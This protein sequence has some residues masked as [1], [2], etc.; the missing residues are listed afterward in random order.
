MVIASGV[1][2]HQYGETAAIVF[3]FSSSSLRAQVE[4]VGRFRRVMLHMT[5]FRLRKC[6]LWVT[7][8]TNFIKGSISPLKSQNFL[9]VWVRVGNV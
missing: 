6:L 1:S 9:L 5:R 2:F 7:V 3:S 4:W 8:T